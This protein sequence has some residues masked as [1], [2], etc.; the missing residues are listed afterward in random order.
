MFKQMEQRL[1]RVV[2]SSW[3]KISYANKREDERREVVFAQSISTRSWVKHSKPSVNTFLFLLECTSIYLYSSFQLLFIF[4]YTYFSNNVFKTSRRV[5][6]ETKRRI[7]N[8]TIYPQFST[9]NVNMNIKYNI[10][11]LRNNCCFKYF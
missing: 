11:S 3:E 9:L 7:R 1:I 8:S 4:F 10:F 6:P 2:F 5:I